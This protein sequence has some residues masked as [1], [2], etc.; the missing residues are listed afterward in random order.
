MIKSKIVY[1]TNPAE[2][3][4]KEK[5]I[6]EKK[7]D[8]ESILC[9]T[10]VSV[11]SP[12]TEVAAYTGMP[13]LR[14]GNPY[15]RLLGYCNVARVLKIGSDVTSISEGDRVLT[16]SCHCS[17]FIIPENEIFSVVP[18]TVESQNAACAYLYHLGYD[19]V[20]KS[21]L[22][23]GNSVVVFGLGVLGLGAVAM[24]SRAGAKV[25]AISNQSYTTEIAK[26]LGAKKVFKRENIKELEN[27]LGG[28]LSDIV[29]STSNSW[30][31]W[32]LALRVAGRNGY[33]GV[34]GFPG[35]GLSKPKNNPLD[36]QYFYAKQ[37]KI[38]AVGHAPEENDSRKFLK[39]NQKDNL[40]FILSEIE[41]GH[42]NPE[43]IISGM[44]AWDKL[45]DAYKSLISRED[46][47]ITYG[48]EWKK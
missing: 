14:P 12:G 37:L 6:D 24:S 36:S 35:R 30:M 46:S 40:S 18:E 29:I 31:D 7:L 10:L 5:I 22:K 28:D 4:F 8:K 23:Y 38:E 25:Y 1:L 26:Q 45:E 3:I 21:D 41:N 2:L 15:P 44:F 34:I 13:P 27:F 39:F 17:H 43:L 16:G 42:L 9:E 47:P 32:D 48:L 33:I 11:I 19:A 20:I